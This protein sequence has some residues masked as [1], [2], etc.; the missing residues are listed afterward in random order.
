MQSHYY[1]TITQPE[2]LENS[3]G[4]NE[5]KTNADK[6]FF[7]DIPIRQQLKTLTRNEYY[8]E[9]RN[10]EDPLDKE[11]ENPTERNAFQGCKTSQETGIAKQAHSD[12]LKFKRQVQEELNGH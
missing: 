4:N 10:F 7:E 11:E 1:Q 12:Y 8:N 9:E 5:L 2:K 6:N 3:K